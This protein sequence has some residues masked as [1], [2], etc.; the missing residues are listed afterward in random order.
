MPVLSLSIKK[1]D[2]ELCL[3]RIDS[4]CTVDML[5]DQIEKRTKIPV[6]RQELLFDGSGLDDDDATLASLGINDESTIRLIVSS[7]AKGL[8]EQLMKRK[9]ELEN[10]LKRLKEKQ[11]VL[12]LE[13]LKEQRD[14]PLESEKTKP[15][16]HDPNTATNNTAKSTNAVAATTTNPAA[17]ASLKPA[18]TNPAAAASL[19]P[20]PKSFATSVPKASVPSVPNEIPIDLFKGARLH[21]GLSFVTT[22]SGGSEFRCFCCSSKAN[23]VYDTPSR[24]TYVLCDKCAINPPKALINK[25]QLSPNR[26]KD[27][28]LPPKKVKQVPKSTKAVAST[29]NVD[30]ASKSLIKKAPND[31]KIKAQKSE[32]PPKKVTQVPTY[33]TCKHQGTY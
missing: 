11:D 6:A 14:A 10:N 24:G 22:T 26:A 1:R 27:A 23:M 31:P 17:A 29:N 2:V 18:P 30:E 25:N 20:A 3:L 32:L 4:N 7:T 15:V 33:Q 28:E 19:K 16:L 9:E 8:R 5:K 21:S 12:Q 13:S